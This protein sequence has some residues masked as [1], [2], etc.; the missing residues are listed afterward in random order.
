MA[1]KC[2][3]ELLVS[4]ALAPGQIVQVKATGTP[5]VV[6]STSNGTIVDNGDGS[7]TVLSLATGKYDW[8]RGSG[9]GTIIASLTQ[10][11]HVDPADV[12]SALALLTVLNGGASAAV[13]RAAL[14]VEAG[15][16]LMAYSARF[17]TLKAF[18]DAMSHATDIFPYYDQDTDAW[19]AAT[20]AAMRTA[21]GLAIGTN[22][23]AY[24]ADLTTLGAGGAGA[25]T[26]L[27][28]GTAATY[29]AT[30]TGEPGKAVTVTL[31]NAIVL[32]HSD[33][34]ITPG[35]SH[36]GKLFIVETG[37]VASGSWTLYV[38]HKTSNGLAYQYGATKL[39]EKSW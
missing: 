38:I 19:I 3:R 30:G 6:A 7:Y 32:P 25:R 35:A 20:A 34:A 36:V 24:D 4:G 39:V 31:D 37:D 23:Q 5:N 33:T 28:L 18:I 8:Y 13:I 11:A 16:D 21:L 2:T 15:V 29:D 17:Q 1:C 9:A 22:V 10:D 27:G 12:D 14:D 26:F